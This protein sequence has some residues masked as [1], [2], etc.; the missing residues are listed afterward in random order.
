MD[1]SYSIP[2]NYHTYSCTLEHNLHITH[3]IINLNP[4]HFHLINVFTIWG[5]KCTP[6]NA[7]YKKQQAKSTL[8]NLWHINQRH[9]QIISSSTNILKQCASTDNGQS[10]SSRTTSH[11]FHIPNMR[12]KPSCNTKANYHWMP[13][14]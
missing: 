3:K 2:I 11:I 14:N 7:V 10:P 8:T 1:A 6:T 4:R 13:G 12:L 5:K 9:N